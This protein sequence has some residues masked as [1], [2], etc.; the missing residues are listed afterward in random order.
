MDGILYQHSLF[1]REGNRVRKIIEP[2]LALAPGERR[3]LRDAIVNY[4]G[5]L[6][7]AAIPVPDEYAVVEEDG[8]V[9]EETLYC[10]VD[11][12]EVLGGACPCMP[13]TARDALAA[14]ARALTPLLAQEGPWE[15]TIDPHPANWCFSDDGAMRYVDFHPARY[16]VNGVLI[17]G[18]PQPSGDEY[19]YAVSRYYSVTG[20][21][22]ALR[23]NAV[24]AG[25]SAMDRVF[26]EIVAEYP[27]PLR[28][29]IEESWADLPERR[30]RNGMPIGEALEPLGIWNIDD[31][32][33]IALCVA[34]RTMAP[35]ESE[36]FL[37]QV[38]ALTHGDFRIPFAVREHKVH[39]AKRLILRAAEQS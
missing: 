16:Q 29:E 5:K 37:N 15:F 34:E 13:L 10:G 1:F 25:G 6:K 19:R 4:Y 36:V 20:I 17:A 7:R 3:E 32:R 24:R 22:R 18:F 27:A 30:L 28:A 11:G 21:L 14:I 23:F 39:E 31:L 12:Y 8:Q 9:V 38:L 26:H 33:E 2:N 35:R